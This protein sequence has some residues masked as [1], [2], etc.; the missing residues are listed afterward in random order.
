M[1][2]H[3]LFL[4]ANTFVPLILTCFISHVSTW[5]LLARN[6]HSYLAL[7][8]SGWSWENPLL[9]PLSLLILM[10]ICNVS[11]ANFQMQIFQ[12]LKYS[13]AHRLFTLL[14]LMGSGKKYL[15]NQ[16]T[17]FVCADSFIAILPTQNFPPFA[18]EDWLTPEHLGLK[19]KLS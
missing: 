2:R 5:L 19:G 3:T 9:I 13:E 12:L 1:R 14:E 16:K 18:L 8:A 6:Q 11:H 17:F 10:Q 7:P 4:N 15:G